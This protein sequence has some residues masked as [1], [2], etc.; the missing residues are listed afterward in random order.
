MHLL[1]AHLPVRETVGEISGPDTEIGQPIGNEPG[2]ISPNTSSIEPAFTVGVV[3]VGEIHGMADFVGQDMGDIVDVLSWPGV[4]LY[5]LFVRVGQSPESLH[6]TT[7]FDGPVRQ[8][9][10]HVVADPIP[11]RLL[12][13]RR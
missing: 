7:E 10:L 8:P 3:V 9:P 12:D 6:W 11:D 4:D 5:P 13:L 2:M 1:S